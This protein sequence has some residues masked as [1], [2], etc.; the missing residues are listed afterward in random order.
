MIVT[1]WRF[2]SLFRLQ[3]ARSNAT[4]HLIFQLL[5]SLPVL[6]WAQE[7]EGIDPTETK[8]VREIVTA[9]KIADGVVKEKVDG[10][11]VG[12]VEIGV[13]V[14]SGT[15]SKRAT[16]MLLTGELSRGGKDERE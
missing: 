5:A 8:T 11:K 7:K 16:L 6:N 4:L 10:G 1:A 13:E 9:T 12:R 14:R 3:C 2:R 15:E